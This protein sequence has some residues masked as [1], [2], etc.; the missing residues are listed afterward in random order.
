MVIAIAI[1]SLK[2]SCDGDTE[3]TG[4]CHLPNLTTHLWSESDSFHP[5]RDAINNC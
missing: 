4:T 3:T 5:I 2:I 1:A